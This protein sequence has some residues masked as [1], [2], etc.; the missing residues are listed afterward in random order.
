MDGTGSIA[1]VLPAREG[2]GPQGAGAIAMVVRAYAKAAGEAVIVLG[3]AQAFPTYSDLA[4]Q[5]VAGTSPWLYGMNILRILRR[6]RAKVIEVHQQ[7]R[8]ARLL[9]RFLPTR[10]VLLFLH[11]DPLSM[12]GL[13]S[14]RARQR[15]LNRLHRVICVSGYLRQRYVDGLRGDH[16]NVVVLHN[17]LILKESPRPLIP[18]KR[19]I[20]YAGRI[21]DNKGIADF[22]EACR[23]A[24]PELPGWRA[25]IIGGDRFGPKSPE[26]R[27]FRDMR[28]TASALGIR[29]DGPQP[30][31]F[32][33]NAMA[34]A[35]IVV[36]PSR[37]PEP[38]G[39]TALEA[40]ASGAALI[41]ARTGGLPE[42]A[43]EAAW[44]F[45]SGDRRALADAIRDLALDERLR[46]KL[47]G[48]GLARA[49]LFDAPVIAEQLRALRG[50]IPAL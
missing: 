50:P 49:R 30:H 12:R 35:A 46:E 1:M 16:D 23:Q 41:A 28:D 33:L 3:G 36:V 48:S 7:P 40:L 27:F 22:I 44:Y 43:G 29:F 11:N 21:V 18:R 5:Q 25:R 34:G 26:T 19:E 37:W 39:L 8:L 4:F 31:E 47:G 45:N 38:F 17:P 15:S 20:L 24:L 9:A 32:V 14:V 6:S 10:R 13:V 2:F 42:V